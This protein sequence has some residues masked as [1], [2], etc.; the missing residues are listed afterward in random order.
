MDYYLNTHMPLVQE[1]WGPYGL[2]SWKVCYAQLFRSPI[3]N[4]VDI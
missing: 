4:Q 1:K 3:P 2:K